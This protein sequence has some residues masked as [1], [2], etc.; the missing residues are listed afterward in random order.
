MRELQRWFLYAAIVLTPFQDTI[1]GSTPLG[2]VG[3]NISS[4]PLLL[5]ALTGLLI[6]LRQGRFPVSR[7]ALSWATYALILSIAYVAFWGPESH[8]FSVIYK[9]ASMGLTCFLC[10][11]AVFYADLSP[12]NGLNY[13]I[14]I[15]FLLVI[16]GVFF[17]DLGLPGTGGI[18]VSPLIHITADHGG[19][20]WRSF[21]VEPSMFSATVISLGLASAQLA[22][23]K[24]QRNV[25]IVSS[26]ILLVLSKSKGALLVIAISG[27]IILFLKRPRFIQA[28]QYVLGACA[29][30]IPMGA[31]VW[32]NLTL[33][34]LAQ[35]TST[36][37]TRFSMAVWTVIVVVHNPLGVGLSGLYQAMTIYLPGA[38]DW[39]RSVSPVPLNFG[40]V[41]EYVNG[42]NVP[43]DAK[44]F[45]LEY[46]V[47]FGL[48]FLVSYFIFA[49][50][51]V[52][53]LE[54]RRQGLLLVA[55]VFLLVSFATY[56]NALALYAAYLPLGLGYREYR[57]W[58][59]SRVGNV[60][61]TFNPAAN[62]SR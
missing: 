38:M 34:D 31:L 2:F 43:L 21:S 42:T 15:A 48:P 10:A 12:T 58:K 19:G 36:F 51:V 54:A 61:R 3:A 46:T 55:V 20:R 35:A 14:Q 18:A 41:A 40:E 1:L 11:Y 27:L 9:T 8:G 7:G 22:R 6:W 13:S 29:V 17:C 57:L 33:T 16:V 50:R 60:D 4:I 39:V 52:T 53:A 30:A 44:C 26:T 5:C 32:Q 23:S 62:L 45:L 59:A 49:K 37:A 28:V 56:V 25:M 47:N 24:L